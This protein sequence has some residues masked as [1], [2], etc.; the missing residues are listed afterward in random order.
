MNKNIRNIAVIA[1][2]DHGKTTLVDALLKQTHVFR[3]NQEEMN[4]SRILDS[5]D[6]EREKGITILAKNC[7]INYKG[8]KINI[9]DTP[10]HADFSGEVERT[11]NMSDG[12]L[13]IVDAQEG[14]MPQTRFV[15]KKALELDL[16]VIV[17]INKID[18]KYARAD[19]VEKKIEEL[20]LELATNDNQLDYS[21]LF[22]IGRKGAVFSEKPESIEGA[23]DVTPLLD[24]IINVVPPPHGDKDKPFKMFVTSFHYDSHIGKIAIGKIDQGKIKKSDKIVTASNPDK[25]FKAEKI[26]VPQGLEMT[27]VDEAVAGDIAGIAG[28]PN[29]TIGDTI[30]DP[31]EP[32]SLG[33]LSIGEPTL[34]ITIG[35][36]TSPLSGQEAQYSTSRQ[37]QQR[38]ERELESDL[39]LRMEVLQSGKMKVSGRGELHL[40]ILLETLRREG[41]EMEV[42]KPEVIIKQVDGKKL[43]PVEEIN[44]IVPNDHIGVISQELGKRYANLQKMNPIN[45][46]ETEFIYQVPTRAILGLKSLLLTQTKGTVLFSSQLSGYEP[47]GKSLPKLRKGVLISSQT[48]EVL[49]YGLSGAQKRGITFVN[50]T[51][52]VYEGMIVGLNAKDD[53]IRVN[54]CKG[55]QLTNMR[56]KSSDG[57]IQLTPPTILSIE[58]SLDFLEA[59][60]LLEITPQS[61]RLR[62]KYLTE[63]ESKR[64]KR[65]ESRIAQSQ[66]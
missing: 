42:G 38:L 7:S 37:L 43:E 10:G 15:L 2:V 51:Q 45:A 35:P 53:D 26:M 23:G 65:L 52:K 33:T 12:V 4:M 44:I 36:N 56:S 58:Q 17:V 16:K 24:A 14:P 6:L 5:N 57:I 48:G 20:F 8:V 11:L 13:L 39:S 34:H 18:K 54:V 55:K 59:D 63:I 31:S 40:A 22:A 3:E 62:K 9:T 47:I 21:L 64:N 30:T 49:A 50:P 46:E 41:Y 66:Q 32:S 25:K 29:I 61:L 27:E 1:H 60:E 19:Y 28:I